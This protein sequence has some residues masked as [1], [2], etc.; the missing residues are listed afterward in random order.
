MLDFAQKRHSAQKRE[1]L[2]K[3]TEMAGRDKATETMAEGGYWKR[4]KR[5]S[6]TTHL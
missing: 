1:T 3:K 2:H 4:Q 5:Q 6:Q